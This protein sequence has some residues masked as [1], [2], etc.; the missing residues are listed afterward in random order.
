MQGLEG[1]IPGAALPRYVLD[2]PQGYGKISLLSS[3]IKK[4]KKLPI[5]CAQTDRIQGAVYEIR[6]PET[7]ESKNQ[8]VRKHFYLDLFYKN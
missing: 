7:Q 2:I 4:I 6:S 1:R 5:R 3:Q 8:Q